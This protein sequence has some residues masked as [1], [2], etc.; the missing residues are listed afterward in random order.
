MPVTEFQESVYN[1]L[2]QIP[3]GRVTT[4]NSLAKALHT[5]PRAVGNALRTT[6][7]APEAPCHRCIAAT[8]YINGFDGAVISKSSYRISR[9]SGTVE[10]KATQ[11]KP[12]GVKAEGVKVETIPPSGLNI[13]KKL[14]LLREEGVEFDEKGMVRERNNVLFDGPWQI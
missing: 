2:T 14:K 4:Y 10:G 12:R 13:S 1:L 3:A 5:S 6:P 11:S 8:G 7:F 9:N